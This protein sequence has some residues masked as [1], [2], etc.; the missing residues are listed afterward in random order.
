MTAELNQRKKAE[1]NPDSGRGFSAVYTMGDSR[2]HFI[3]KVFED[4]E[5][6]N[7]TEKYGMLLK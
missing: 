5:F 1:F 7:V 6:Q 4:F 3:Q 2:F